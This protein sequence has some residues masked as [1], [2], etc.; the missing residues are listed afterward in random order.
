MDDKKSGLAQFISKDE[1]YDLVSLEA[2]QNKSLWLTD[3]PAIA[4]LAQA[5]SFLRSVGI[6]LR[7]WATNGI[8]LASMYQACTGNDKEKKEGQRRAIEFTNALLESF[9]AIEVNMIAGRICLIDETWVPALYRLATRDRPYTQIPTLSPGA[10]QAYDLLLIK[11][12]ITAGDLRKKMGIK[13]GLQED[14]AYEALA[15]LQHHFLVDR[16]PFAI[17]EKGIPY[18]SKEGYP[19]H[20]FHEAHLELVTAARKLTIS[21]A[22]NFFLSAYLKSAVFCPAKKMISMFQSFLSGSE[23]EGALKS[24]FDEKKILLI[25]SKRDV[26]VCSRSGLRSR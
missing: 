3:K 23:I 24:L 18:L 19:Y 5:S 11:G 13:S 2:K 14:P 20:F 21:Q 26:L 25:S 15:E 17:P 12:E 1:S 16:G 4:T 9:Q 7:Y 8:P 10:R 22:T 6:V